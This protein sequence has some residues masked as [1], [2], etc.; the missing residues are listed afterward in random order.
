M[1][2]PNHHAVCYS[3]LLLAAYAAEA[4][5]QSPAPAPE[6]SAACAPRASRAVKPCEP[7]KTVV[8]LEMQ[9]TFSLEAPAQ[10]SLQCAAAMEVVYTQ[11][12]TVAHVE[13]TVDHENC[14]ASE[15]E[16]RLTV[17]V[18]A[19]NR[20]IQSFAF[21]QTWRREDD[22]PV[23]FEAHYPIPA[24]VDLLSVRPR[25]LRCMCAEVSPPAAVPA[26]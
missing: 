25:Q 13:G 1:A 22:R 4:L 7:A 3:A 24:N 9:S 21:V 16:H 15:G 2:R 18:R 19:E 5:S 8:V 10:E 17:N 20:E 12:D 6:A 26:D 14:G 23:T 11:R